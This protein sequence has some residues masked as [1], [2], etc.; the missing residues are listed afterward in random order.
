MRKVNVRRCISKSLLGVS[1]CALT[2]LYGITTHAQ[3]TGT[4]PADEQTDASGERSGGLEDI[5]VTATR[6]SESLQ[7]VPLAV[8]AIGNERL[9]DSNVTGLQAVT[10]LSPGIQIQPQFVPGNAVFQIRGQS[11]SD[12]GPT[13]DPSVGIYFDD[14]YIARSTGSLV[15]L[16]DLERVEVLKGPQGTLFGKNNA[17][18]VIRL[19]S[20]K[21]T[22]D[23]EGYGKISY[24]SF[25]RIAVE[26]VLNIPI[27]EI[28]ALRVVGQ[29]VDKSDGYGT[30][31]LNGKPIDTERTYFGRASLQIEP[32]DTLTILLQGDYSDTRGGG[33]VNY[34]S[35]YIPNSSGGPIS[36][37]ALAVE[38]GLWDFN[39]ATQGA[40]IAQ[41]AAILESLERPNGTRKV[42]ND[43]RLPTSDSYTFDP[44]TRAFTI[45]GGELDTRNFSKTWGGSAH[46]DWDLGGA[47][48]TSITA[49]RKLDYSASYNLDGLPF[50]LLDSLQTA[51]AKQFSQEVLLNGTSLADRLKWTLGGLY[52]SENAL[53]VDRAVTFAALVALQGNAGT[54]ANQRGKNKSYGL[55]G[56]G[57]Y[58]LTD[59]LSVTGGVRWSRDNRTFIS[60]AFNVAIGTGAGICVFDV[61]NGLATLPAFKPPCTLTQSSSE[62]Q[63]TYSA[64]AQ[65]QFDPNRQIYVRTS[66][67]YRA[68]GF[69]ARILAPVALG[70]FGAEV[71][72]DYEIGLKADW[73][74][75]R[76]RTNI[77]VFQSK[78]TGVQATRSAVVNNQA[79]PITE[80]RGTRK[81]T[82]VEL[83]IQA[84][85]ADFLT[86][87]AGVSFLDASLKDPLNPDVFWVPLVPKWA[88]NIGATINQPI[89]STVTA[90]LRGD[91]TVRGKMY[92]TQE[93]VRDSNG[94]IL[95]A[96]QYDDLVLAS[97]RLTFDH[98]PSGIEFAIYARNL[99]NKLYAARQA[100]IGGLGFA[101]TTLGEPRVIGAELK[102]PFGKR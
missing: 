36:A 43:V 66:R 61:A 84:R 49:Y 59:K 30:N 32:S 1:F 24:E 31:T 6:R 46:V 33:L 92:D 51:N 17:G 76:L 13:T 81:V 87:D 56:Q 55:F 26:G 89:S 34:W 21:P 72:T 97:A 71:V 75:R 50:H 11:N 63:W 77:A 90:K 38:Q 99:T 96:G 73:L 7:R 47:V 82:G 40:A 4:S 52:F 60:N 14:V 39:P 48:L 28:A 35:N 68:G 10:L 2:G 85:P 78:G 53:Q 5:V 45:N 27:S 98:A 12:T 44:V 94:A 86:F 57:T 102:V 101:F 100:T 22:Q 91:L 3:T 41:A 67:G 95:V 23:F 9:S 62:D 64:A 25:D 83:D 20:K 65:Y 19:V 70:F 42:G 58:E 16:V 18:G 15:N 74:D 8:A 93:A 29:F 79:V 80:N 54:L 69:N 37:L 88:W